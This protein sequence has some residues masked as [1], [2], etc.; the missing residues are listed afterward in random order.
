MEAISAQD[1]TA[2]MELMSQEKDLSKSGAR[3][4]QD[5]KD[6][7]VSLTFIYTK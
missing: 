2:A 5:I 4:L 7:L 6:N 3:L 1:K